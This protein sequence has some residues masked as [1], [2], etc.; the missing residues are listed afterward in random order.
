MAQGAVASEKILRDQPQLRDLEPY[1]RELLSFLGMNRRMGEAKVE[2]IWEQCREDPE[3]YIFSGIVRTFDERDRR[4]PRKPFMDKPYLRKTLQHLHDKNAG[5]VC[6]VSKSRQLMLSWLICAY[7]TWEARFHPQARVLVQSKKA[8]DSWS[9]V[10]RNN[11]LNARCA[12]IERAMPLFMRSKG[13]KPTRGELWYDNGSVIAGIPQGPDQFRS[14]TASL[15]VC[16]EAAFQDAFEDAYKAA[17]SMAKGYPD[18]PDSGGRIVLI[19]TAAAGS[20]Y[21][22]LV[23]ENEEEAA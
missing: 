22:K 17:L 4:N 13:L 21:S 12:F 16:D 18:D 7:A 9:L 3:F 10:Y 6:A 19:T 14:Y 2:K 23:E 8:E 20:Y 1:D 11:W 5:D 15:V